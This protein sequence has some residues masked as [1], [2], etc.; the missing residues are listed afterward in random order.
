LRNFSEIASAVQSKQVFFY[1]GT[2]DAQVSA[3]WIMEDS[4]SFSVKPTIRLYHGL[5]H[6]FS[7]MTGEYGEIKTAG[8]LSSSMLSDLTKDVS[9]LLN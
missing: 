2:K 1:Q 5:G 9:G 6:C 8:P 4:Y 7:P 3:S